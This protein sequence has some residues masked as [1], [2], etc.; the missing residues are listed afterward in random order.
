MKIDFEKMRKEKEEITIKKDET[1]IQLKIL[2]KYMEESKKMFEEELDK[3]VN[4]YLEATKTISLNEEE[5]KRLNQR[6]ALF[7]ISIQLATF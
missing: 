6:I 3:K 1:E 4:R 5:I 7:M 2:K